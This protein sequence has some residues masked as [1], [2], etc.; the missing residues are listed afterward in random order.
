MWQVS[1][2]T[3][4]EAEDAVGCLLDAV[5]D[6]PRAVYCDEATGGRLVSIYT[7]RLPRA[8]KLVRTQLGRELRHV[9][10][11]GLNLGPARIRIERLPRKNWAESWKLH[12]T[13]ID[14][15]GVLLI[16]PKW[17]KQPLQEGQHLVVLNPGMSF[18]TGHHPT[19]L[20]CLEQL[21]RCRVQ[22]QAQSFLDIGTGSG[23]LAIA[24][25][26]LGYTPVD[27]FDN[28]PAAVRI[29]RDNVRM[30]RARH[31]L[32]P[33]QKD[34]S[35]LKNSRART[36]DVVCANLACDLLVSEASQICARVKPG[37]KLIVA[38]I[39]AR[40]FAEVAKKLRRF[41]LTLMVK[42][43]D[44]TWQSGEFVLR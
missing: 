24:A 36:Y 14:V 17:H 33:Q 37:G 6:K 13:P 22:G 44:K 18:G 19:T 27:A 26:K 28:D 1:I 21:V 16:R 15:D 4:A 25:A 29:S 34:L 30:N 42:K 43:S 23:I 20:F 8:E 9:R 11:C 31:Q 12:F 7:P 2:L 35:K 38:G 10:R 41:N 5:F 32:W 3:S 40:Q 39:L